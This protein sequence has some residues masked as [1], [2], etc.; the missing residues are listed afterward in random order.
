[1]LNRRHQPPHTNQP[2]CT[3]KAST[4]SGFSDARIFLPSSRPSISTLYSPPCTLSLPST[5]NPL[6]PSS[7]SLPLS[8]CSPLA[9]A[10]NPI[11]ATFTLLKPH[12]THPLCPTLV[13]NLVILYDACGT[14]A[15]SLGKELN[16]PHYIA[17]LMPPLI[18]KP[19]TLNPQPSI[20]LLP[21]FPYR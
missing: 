3:P 15:E 1:M 21:C 12:L 9:P 14:L 20:S 19:S 10:M 4:A 18:G 11:S 7:F 17:V 5:R 16:Q 13:Q 2:P 6:Q 8:T